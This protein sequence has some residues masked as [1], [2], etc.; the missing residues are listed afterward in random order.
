MTI[1]VVDDEP[2]ILLV[3][4]DKLKELGDEQIICCESIESALSVIETVSDLSRIYLDYHLPGVKGADGILQVSKA[5]EKITPKPRI[6]SISG[7]TR[8]EVRDQS[9]ASGARTFLDK[10][11][12]IVGENALRDS[13]FLEE[14]RSRDTQSDGRIDKLESLL[15]QVSKDLSHLQGQQTHDEKRIGDIHAQVNA[16]TEKLQPI[17]DFSRFIEKFPFKLKGFLAVLFTTITIGSSLFT[18]L[19]LSD[20]VLDYIYS[21]MPERPAKNK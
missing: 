20:K 8:R 10:T 14:R 5:T 19:G 21:R 6:F 3:L 2:D 11:Q 18:S 7:D 16:N 4:E 17:N 1:L 13:Y 15:W 9:I 12:L